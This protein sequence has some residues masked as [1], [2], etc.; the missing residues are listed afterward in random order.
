M[1]TSRSRVRLTTTGYADT[2]AGRQLVKFFRGGN[3]VSLEQLRVR[4][5]KGPIDWTSLPSRRR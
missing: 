2:E 5:A 3:R 1:G 4:F